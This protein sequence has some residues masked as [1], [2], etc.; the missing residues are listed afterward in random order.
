MKMVTSAVL[1]A[2]RVCVPEKITS[3][4]AA[5]RMLLCEVSP[6]TQRKASSRL[7]LP[8]PFGPTTPVSPFSISKLGRFDEGL[9]AQESKP[10]DVHGMNNLA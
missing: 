5:A 3:S 9:E 8:Q 1:R 2:G 4:M 10:V 6:I 7:D